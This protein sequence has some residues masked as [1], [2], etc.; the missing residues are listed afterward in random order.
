VTS[1][2]EWKNV[3]IFAE[4][5]PI[6][7]GFSLSAEK[8]DKVMLYGPSGA[9]KTSILRSVLGF[10]PISSGEIFY[11]GEHL[12]K[13]KFWD[14]RSTIAYIPQDPDIGE[15]P[16]IKLIESVFS[17]KAN[18]CHPSS[19]DINALFTLFALPLSFR[20]KDFERLSG[21]E[22]QRVGI[23]IA[24][25]LKRKIFFL[26]EITSSLDADLKKVVVRYFT[27]LAEST[28][29]I[30]SH[31]PEWKQYNAVRTIDIEKYTAGTNTMKE[32]TDT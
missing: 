8:N 6:I 4:N 3:H 19:E 7:S 31:D 13:R 1:V 14:I 29:I 26:D 27:G 21:G 12:T 15:G 2:L 10:I 18:S 25:L 32:T 20:D 11:K 16:V 28:Q 23:I 17:Y 9:G 22:K 24:L 30:V 5:T